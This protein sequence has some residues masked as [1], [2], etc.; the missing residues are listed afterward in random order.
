M[1]KIDPGVQIQVSQILM[2]MF[3]YFLLVHCGTS[4]SVIYVSRVKGNDSTSCGTQDSPCYSISQAVSHAQ[5]RSS[6]LLDSTNTKVSPYDCKPLTS[7]HKGIYVT[8]TLSFYGGP[9]LTHVS[10][11]KGENWVV[12]GSLSLNSVHVNFTGIAFQNCCLHFVETSVTAIH[13]LFTNTEKLVMNFTNLHQ[14]LTSLSLNYVHFES[15]EACISMTSS[16]VHTKET[17]F[18]SIKIKNSVF[19]NNGR[20]KIPILLLPT[21]TILGVDVSGMHYVDIQ[22]QNSSCVNTSL[23]GMINVTNQVGHTTFHIQDVN[24]TENGLDTR[25]GNSLIV[26]TGSMVSFAI[27]QSRVKK[28][29]QRFAS[30][31]STLAAISIFHTI[32]DDFSSQGNGGMFYVESNTTKLSI[33][34]CLFSN[35]KVVFPG[36]GGLVFVF[37][38]HTSIIIE[39]SILTNLTADDRGGVIHVM[40]KQ[41]ITASVNIRMRNSRFVSNMAQY[42]GCVSLL[43]RG[44]AIVNVYNSTFNVNKASVLGGFFWA[45]S[46]SLLQMFVKKSLFEGNTA[47]NGGCISV[48]ENKSFV[49]HTVLVLTVKNVTFTRNSASTGVMFVGADVMIISFS[50]VLFIENY[51]SAIN[52]NKEANARIS[53]FSLTASHV[54][55]IG[56]LAW[57]PGGVL[58]AA[59]GIKSTLS[60][61][62]VS[63]LNNTSK[64]GPG[65][66]M[67][68]SVGGP[69]FEI[70][71]KRCKFENNTSSLAGAIYVIGNNGVLG[72]QDVSFL[73]N[74]G[75]MGVGGAIYLCG[76]QS[77]EILLKRCRFEN[78]T[79]IVVGGAI[80][81]VGSNGVFVSEDSIFCS[82]VASRPGGALML[83]TSNSTINLI[84]TTFINNTSIAQAGGAVYLDINGDTKV[85]IDHVKF[86]RNTAL[87]SSGAGLAI[88]SS[89]DTLRESGCNEGWS[90]WNYSSLVE[91]RNSHFMHNIAS[92]GGAVSI[93]DGSINFTNCTFIDNIA[94]DQGSHITNY[95]TNSLH[96]TDCKFHQKD[97]VN[98]STF[99]QTYSAGPLVFINTTL[100]QQEL[101]TITTLIDV[102]ID[103]SKGG[104]V[105]VND[106]TSIVCPPG[107]SISWSNV[108]YSDWVNSS[109]TLHVTV[110]RLQC[111]VCERGTY[112]LQRGHAKGFRI[113]HD[114]ACLPCPY[115]AECF[116]TIKSKPNFWG[117]L[118]H[119]NVPA[120]NFTRCPD[121]YCLSGTQTPEGYVNSCNGNREGWLCGRC[122]SDYS[123]TLF[124]ADCKRSKD[125]NDYWFWLVTVALV[126]IMALFLVF[127]PPV[128]TFAVKQAFWFKTHC[129]RRKR[130]AMA[131][132]L[133]LPPT[134]ESESTFLLSTEEIENEQLQSVGFLEI[135]FYFYQ[136]SNLLLTST[137]SEQ[138]FKTRV[139]LPIQGF[140]NF[141]GR[142]LNYSSHV[143]P[144]SGLTPQSKQILEVAPVFGTLVGI[145]FIYGLHYILCKVFRSATPTLARCL[146]ATIETMLLGYIKIANVS[147]S[148]IRCVPI[149][150]EYRWFYNGNI[151]CYQWWQ[152]VLIGFDVM[153]VAPFVLVLALGAVKL[154]GGKV[155][156]TH[157]LLACV[158]PLPFLIL[159][160]LQAL[161][162][163]SNLGQPTSNTEYTEV[164]KTVLLSPFREPEEDK[165]GALYWESIFIVRRLVLVCLFF[166]TDST[167]R[168]LCMAVVCVLALLHHAKMKPFRSNA[169]NIAETTSLL[170]LVILAITN[171][172]K[173]FYANSKED[174][175]NDYLVIFQILDWIEV[176]LLGLLPVLFALMVSLAII[177]VTARLI[178]VVCV[179]IYARIYTGFVRR[180]NERTNL[181]DN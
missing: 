156:A 134:N 125:C 7:H 154:H 147:L 33:K 161:G 130:H 124:S 69:S 73:N 88:T 16:S 81:V 4:Q 41:N 149:G 29:K 98:K 70:L 65:G 21:W 169:A 26:L 150:S 114:F 171:M 168:L 27:S 108:S 146:G 36:N 120:L 83:E 5:F 160:L 115:G 24:F 84:N 18:V 68:L 118:I 181:V 173:S 82:N 170:A 127:K 110:L 111:N 159:W 62:D 67:Y 123:E 103:V 178:F 20:R 166:I 101:S 61:Q 72:C 151:V 109:C 155:S 57:S 137:S 78:N 53:F 157:F 107:M 113:S 158:F 14:N 39:S 93:I 86:K 77:F 133:S 34:D 167:L 60:F 174:V 116:L 25:A 44:K 143:C 74:N 10:C 1:I 104:K 179:G 19:T 64:I 66:A 58:Y 3:L 51:G 176:I 141:E 148:L 11:R 47:G 99:V 97:N 87:Q 22:I 165:T 8:K 139:L 28:N 89:G 35:G 121:G 172:Y 175:S 105:E 152:I 119:D 100:D 37:G 94:K 38:L 80:Y 6:I 40:A 45:Y 135:I 144:F 122:K 49:L 76:I 52:V 129:E 32:V 145:Y 56:N 46:V 96:L 142:Y 59:L 55:F 132:F 180:T 102:L 15:N 131:E 85:Y 79:S 138:L 43:S 128:V 95:G 153:V 92:R 140:F 136:I 117:Y 164:L 31:Y 54:Q 71:L 42:G 12:N 30:I 63:F 48:Q 163:C 50:L 162:F 2:Y 17:S 177:S 112:S 91:V 90:V 126:F 9:T 75:Q 106:F 13:C 23:S